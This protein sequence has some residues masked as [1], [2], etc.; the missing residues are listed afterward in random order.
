MIKAIILYF[1]LWEPKYWYR[2]STNEW[3]LEVAIEIHG[4]YHRTSR[5]THK[6][7]FMTNLVWIQNVWGVFRDL[8]RYV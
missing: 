2:E 8:E 4:K 7:K 5:Y 1:K 6:F 3:V